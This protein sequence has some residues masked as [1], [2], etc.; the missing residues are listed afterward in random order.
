MLS[1]INDLVTNDEGIM[2]EYPVCVRQYLSSRKQ[3]VQVLLSNLSGAEITNMQQ[4]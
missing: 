2:P 4:F 1:T 3:D